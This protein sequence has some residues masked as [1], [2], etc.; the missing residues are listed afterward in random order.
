MAGTS[1]A[2]PQPEAYARVPAYEGLWGR[3]LTTGDV[4]RALG[5]TREGVRYLVRDGQL[6]CQATRARWRI[7][8]PDDVL[9]LADRRTRARLAGR[10]PWRQRLGPRGQPRQLTFGPVLVR[11]LTVTRHGQCQVRDATS[12]RK[13]A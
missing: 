3:P 12:L 9:W 11:P 1:L 7:F 8:R 4:S 10:L 6:P 5:L 2:K 13:S